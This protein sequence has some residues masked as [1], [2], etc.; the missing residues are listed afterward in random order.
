MGQAVPAIEAALGFPLRVT[1]EAKEDGLIWVEVI[2][3]DKHYN[4]QTR[5]Q[6]SKALREATH[7]S[8][9]F[10]Y[11]EMDSDAPYAY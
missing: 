4:G 1:A 2:L 11:I 7:P 9:Q 8:G 6:V 5:A 3:P 10:I